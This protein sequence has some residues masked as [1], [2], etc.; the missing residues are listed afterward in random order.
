MTIYRS[1]REIICF[2]WLGI[3]YQTSTQTSTLKGGG[4]R[5]PDW[6]GVISIDAARGLFFKKELTRLSA[7]ISVF[8][9]FIFTKDLM[10]ILIA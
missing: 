10:R 2:V 3:Q 9:A 4:M 6:Y 8:V 7:F 1:S 5:S